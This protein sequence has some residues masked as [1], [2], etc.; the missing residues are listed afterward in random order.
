MLLAY[1]DPD[2]QPLRSAG[3]LGLPAGLRPSARDRPGWMTEMIAAEP[4]LSG[5]LL[6]RLGVVR[7]SS[8]VPGVPS[9]LEAPGRDTLP[10]SSCGGHP[11]LRSR[12][13]TPSSSPA[14]AR[15]STER[16][17]SPPSRGTPPSGQA[18][19]EPASRGSIVARQAFEASL[20][21]QRG[22]L[23]VG[24]SHEG[25]TR[26]NPGGA[27]RWSRPRREGGRCHGEQG[28][29]DRRAQLDHARDGG[30]RPQLVP[31][32]RLPGPDP[33]RPSPS[34]PRSPVRPPTRIRSRSGPS[35]LLA[36]SRPNPPNRSP[37]VL[38]RLPGDHRAGIRRRP[39]RRPRAGAQGGGGVLAGHDVARHGD[40]PARPP[41]RHGRGDRARARPG[42][43][44]RARSPVGAGTAGA[45]S[46]ISRRD[47]A[48]RHPRRP[49]WTATGPP[50]SP[51]QAGSSLPESPTLPGPVAALVGTA[52]PLQLLTERIARARGTNP[53][54]IRRDQLAYREAASL[55]D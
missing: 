3:A 42:G 27:P 16:W 25:G 11:D 48:G 17:H 28:G 40:V 18:S 22:G 2:A 45:G 26:G 6:R 36:W 13:A 23:V 37:R 44:R 29:A 51:R 30:D 19:K 15:A 32:D 49:T 39:A 1:P 31:H 4:A 35:S 9:K 54:L 7:R 38:G 5:R 20:A 21:P 8:G 34:A 55:A 24:I 10:G 43:S 46:R 12:A 14:A 52:T 47:P 53:D 41:A 50:S 33:R